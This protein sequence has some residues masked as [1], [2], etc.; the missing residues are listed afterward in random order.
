MRMFTLSPRLA[1]VAARLPQGVRL[2]DIGCDHGKLPIY[3]AV[4]LA[5][6]RVIACDIRPKPLARA[7][8]GCR[9]FGVEDRVELRLGDGLAPVS[10]E[11]CTYVTVCGMGGE[12]IASILDAAPWTR[13]GAHT[14]I[15]QPETS[16]HKLR[17]FLYGAGYRIE[18]E[19]AVLD[20]GRVYTVLCV[21]GGAQPCE[22]ALADCFASPALRARHDAA[23]DAYLARIYTSLGRRMLG[24]SPE[25][26]QYAAL[27]EARR[28]LEERKDGKSLAD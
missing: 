3:A 9:R 18:D 13:G 20:S 19:E 7:A 25:S 10:P 6:E 12:T 14:L 5:P 11:E 16:A 28:L 23:A 4:R 27:V 1:C 22:A 24:E 15:L 17:Q 8:E 26:A 21:R 2:A